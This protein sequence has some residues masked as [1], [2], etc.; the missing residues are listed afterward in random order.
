MLKI[1][2]KAE[3]VFVVL[4]I[5][6]ATVLVFVNVVLRAFGAGTTWSEE[7]IRYLII[8]LT[9]IGGS[10]CVRKGEHVGIELLPEFL[11]ARF[12]WV[13]RVLVNLIVIL[14]LVLLIKYSTELTMFTYKNGQTAPA[15]GIPMYWVYLCLPLGSLLMVIR[16]LADIVDAWRNKQPAEAEPELN[17]KVGE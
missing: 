12:R 2:D 17:G 14:F 4:T 5:F 11:P 15:L 16:Y 3:N 13:L 9:F 10:I 6:L 8:W 1:L 7:L